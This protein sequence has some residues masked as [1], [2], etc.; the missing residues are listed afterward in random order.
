MPELPSPE[1]PLRG[2]RVTLRPYAERDIPEILIAHQDDPQ[3]HRWLGAPRPPSGAELG[4]A[5]ERAD[6]DRRHGLRLAL[7]ITESGDDRCV[8]QVSLHSIDWAMGHGELALWLAPE[9]RRRGYGREALVLAAGWLLERG[10]RRIDLVIAADN[11]PMLRAAAAAGA[12]PATGH[13]A[14]APDA[15]RYVLARR[16]E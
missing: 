9:A 4:R 10:L 8:G 3:L 6:E 15:V 5:A 14:V 16:E 12:R 1:Q 7:T 2:E 13:S 11:E